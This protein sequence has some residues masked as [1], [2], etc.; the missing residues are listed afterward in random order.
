MKK[1][2]S[3]LIWF[4]V[5][6][7]IIIISIVILTNFIFSIITGI[8]IT[9]IENQVKFLRLAT[10]VE[11]TM[12]NE[13]ESNFGKAINIRNEIYTQVPLKKTP[14]G[15]NFMDL[16]NSYLKSVRDKT[17]GH[18]CGGLAMVYATA[19]ESQG[20][21]A[22]YVGIFS[23]DKQ[24]YDGHAT[25][26][27]WYKGN[28]CASDPTF[29]VMFK[30]KGEYISYSQLYKVIKNGEEY[31][32]VSNGFPVFPERVIENY[33]IKLG[34]LVKYMVIHPCEIWAGRKKYKYPMMLF[35]KN[36]DGAI[37]FE[38]GKRRDVKAFGG[39]YKYLNQ[40][41]LR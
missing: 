21:P 14:K 35:P 26:E 4:G 27:F 13:D 16:D 41:Q 2:K 1:T 31:E 15:F 32:I 24:P 12:N 19:L 30:Y 7:Y 6:F 17:V 38:G 36:W 11:N 20:I 5:P 9:E 37:T 40:G 28:W 8:R 18:I 29:N 33:Y 3:R 22:R 34:D 25:I 39:I 10:I 23:D